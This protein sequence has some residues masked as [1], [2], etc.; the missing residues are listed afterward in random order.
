VKDE[1][2]QTTLNGATDNTSIKID[3]LLANLDNETIINYSHHFDEVNPARVCINNP[4]GNSTMRLDAVIEYSAGERYTEFYNIQNY[5]ITNSTQAQNISL[6]N[7]K[8]SEGEEFSIVYKDLSFSPVS[9]V[10]IQIQRKYV[11]EGLFKTIEIP[12]SGTNGFTI[13]HLVPADVVYNLIFLRE[14][15]VLDTFTDVIAQCQNP[16]F[17]DCE[18]N[19]NALITGQD[20]LSL[21]EE[22]DIY[23]S[24]SFA[25]ETR[26]VSVNYGIISGV[27]GLAE[28]DVYL[29]DNKGNTTACSDSLTAAGGTLTCSVPD[30]YGNTTVHAVFTL[31]GDVRREGYISMNPKPSELYGGSLIFLAVVMVLFL[32]GIGVQENPAIMGIFLIL[33]TIILVALNLVYSEGWL[34]PGA[35]VL[36]LIIA[37]V[38][39]IIKGGQKR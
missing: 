6:Y 37:V 12:M 15:V 13:A 33:G 22:S 18:I 34:G 7:L 3:I 26:T 36:W 28:L 16:D 27:S 14:G 30:N 1:T 24:M 35:T 39:I 23:S 38:L 11:D 9:D 19:L 4:F 32:V 2:S 29:M 8:E 17:N 25:P 20:L 31:D 5:Q 21:V 10:V